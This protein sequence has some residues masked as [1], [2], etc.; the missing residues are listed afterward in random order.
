MQRG[1]T[2]WKYRMEPGA[3]YLSML[4]VALCCAASIRRYSWGWWHGMLGLAP[5]HHRYRFWVVGQDAASAIW[6]PNPENPACSES[7]YRTDPSLL[8]VTARLR[9]PNDRA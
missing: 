7:G 9:Q 5:G 3:R 1:N 2:V 4:P 6:L 8:I